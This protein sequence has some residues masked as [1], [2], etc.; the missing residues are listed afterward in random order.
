M[1]NAQDATLRNVKASKKR[2]DALAARLDALEA[3]VA[4]LAAD[5]ERLT[6][7]TRD[8]PEDDPVG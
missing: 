5:V 1:A 2:D 8:V 4:R 6:L 3:T 7:K